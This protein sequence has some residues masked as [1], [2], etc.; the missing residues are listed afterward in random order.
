MP[1]EK[2]DLDGKWPKQAVC[3]TPALYDPAH[4]AHNS[5]V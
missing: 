4:H 2:A 5:I 3:V 1:P